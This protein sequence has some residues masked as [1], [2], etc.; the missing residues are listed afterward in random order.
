MAPW[1]TTSLVEHGQPDSV[2][3]DFQRLLG[4]GHNHGEVV[5]RAEDGMV[6][7]AGWRVGEI[8]HGHHYYGLM[9]KRGPFPQGHGY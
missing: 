3:P 5:E 6:H 4:V 8:I 2:A 1:L 9:V 7:S